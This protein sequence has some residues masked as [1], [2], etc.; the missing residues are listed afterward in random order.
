MNKQEAA[1]YFYH[2]QM[3]LRLDAYNVLGN[4]FLE[5][6]DAWLEGASPGRQQDAMFAWCSSRIFDDGFLLY[7]SGGDLD[8]YIS[9]S[10]VAL[11]AGLRKRFGGILP[12]ALIEKTI[13]YIELVAGDVWDEYFNSH[14]E[15][16]SA[17]IDANVDVQGD[18]EDNGIADA[19][20]CQM[21]DIRKL[22]REIPDDDSRDLA[23]K[24]S[25]SGVITAL[26]SYLWA[27]MEWAVEH[28][29][30]CVPAISRNVRQV[31]EQ[32]LVVGQPPD[33]GA[34]PKAKVTAYLRSIIWHN[35]RNVAP[36]LEFGLGGKPPK[37][38]FLNKAASKR[39]HLVHRG[40]LT[41]EGRPVTVQ[42][43]ELD[44]LI[45]RATEFVDAIEAMRLR[46]L[47]EQFGAS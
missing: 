35:W 38:G 19:F 46:R 3:R 22:V 13:A 10:I 12:G 15:D 32:K 41:K 2:A 5:I 45:E 44:A 40:G 30:H 37:A 7:E 29:D 9:G 25:Y 26:E 47:R 36:V 4:G 1:E 11:A 24:F 43:A 6:K 34:E 31:E 8:G 16:V 20:F 18:K 42:L 33:A 17:D 27:T 28:L 14:D 23:L 21:A 39:H